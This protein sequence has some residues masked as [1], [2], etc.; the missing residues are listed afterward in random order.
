MRDVR[1]DEKTGCRQE[2]Q[3]WYVARTLPH[4]E[5]SAQK[6]LLAQGFTTFLPLQDKTIRHA[7]RLKTVS[8]PVFPRY[9]F[10][11]FDAARACWRS[12]NGTIG[13]DRL[14]M[15]G[16]RPEAVRDGVVEA[17]TASVDSEDRLQFHRLLEPGD[18]VRL[19]CGP[20]ADQLGILERLGSHERVQVLLSFMGGAVSVQVARS[21][22]VPAA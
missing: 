9:I 22:V 19:Q 13:V 8:R 18:R 10:V 17:L 1:A 4:N 16:E 2:R 14:L 6:R 12:I 21:N 3:R 15:R 7:R 20:F 5:F 11:R